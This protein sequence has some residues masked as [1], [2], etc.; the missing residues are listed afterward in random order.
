MNTRLLAKR[1]IKIISFIILAIYL[2]VGCTEPRE[3]QGD[4]L[5]FTKLTDL[6][7]RPIW[8]EDADGVK[9]LHASN[10]E[11]TGSNDIY[12]TTLADNFTE[13]VW[14]VAHNH[15]YTPSFGGQYMAISTP[16]P[17][18]GV[19]L[20]DLTTGEGVLRLPGGRNPSW[21]SDNPACLMEGPDS[22][23]MAYDFNDARL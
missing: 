6:T 19:Y 14:S 22:R 3:R 15:D 8:F 16:S 4:P 21:V 1:A 23:L 20:Q 12:A 11:V 9:F 17:V 7:V 18:G 13:T 5:V 10:S 2:Q